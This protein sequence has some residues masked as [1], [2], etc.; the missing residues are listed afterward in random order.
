MRRVATMKQTWTVIVLMSIVLNVRAD[1]PEA[2]PPTRTVPDVDRLFGLV[3]PDPYRWMEGADNAEFQAWLKAQGQYTRVQLDALPAL[4]KWRAKLGA[5]S[6]AATINRL[7]RRVAGRMFFLRSAGGRPGVL[8]VRDAQGAERVLLDPNPPGVPSSTA[9]ITEYSP[10]PDGKL[11]AVN[12]DRG[13]S[14]ITQ[15]SVLDADT[16]GARP[17]VLEA[18]WG[19]FPVLWLPDGSGYTYTQMAPKDE[20]AAGDPMTN[21]RVRVHLLGRAVKDDA[22]ILRPGSNARVP[23]PSNEFAFID[24]SADS[25]YALAIVGGARPEQRLCIAPKSAA[26]SADA[27]WQCIADY[28]DEVQGYDLHGA[29]LYLLSMKGAPNGRI[30]ALDLSKNPADLVEARVVVPESKDTVLTGLASA[31]DSLYVR[32]MTR[33][34]DSYLRL[35]HDGGPAQSLAMP[36]AGASYLMSTRPKED[37]LVFTL[38][39]WTRPRAAYAWDPATRTPTDLKLGESS[40]EDYHDV[41]ATDTEAVSSDGTRVPLTIIAR[42]DA[43]KDGSHLAIVDGYGGYGISEQPYFDPMILE[44]VKAGNVYAIAHVRG[45]GENGNAWWLAGKPPHKERGVE[46]FIACAAQ[47]TKLDLTT[48]RRTAAYGASAGGLLVG[49]AITRAPIRFGAAIIHAGMLNPVRLLA[50]QNGANQIA[51]VG[52]PRTAKGLKEI[53]AM[54]PYQRIGNGVRYPAVM[55]AVGLNDSRVSTWDSGKFAARL[56]TA[57][58]SGMPIWIRT[59]GDA[60]HFND[61]LDDIAAERADEAA[62]LEHVLR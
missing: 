15:V 50:G 57:S 58:S 2:P 34:V 17:D 6:G 45:G 39:G 61:S 30:L 33:G 37:G 16:G 54:D 18:I 38:V 1:A 7:Q 25:A 27:P 51:E 22:I 20:I 5:M 41:M 56:R 47:L 8:M 11:V 4:A 9:T 26:L 14:E 59:N 49:G 35:P 48:P 53:A 32:Q 40:P 24:A 60:G 52:D 13:G 29:V 42:A 10:S 12:V 21:M 46:D 55:L 23:L 44:W 36:F 31:R 28:A 43:A 62:F 19:E 3:L